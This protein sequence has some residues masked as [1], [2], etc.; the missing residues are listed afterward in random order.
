M[1]QPPENHEPK[2]DLKYLF[3]NFAKIIMFCVNEAEMEMEEEKERKVK[4]D[5]QSEK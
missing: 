3:R 2:T 1:E 5:L 4:K